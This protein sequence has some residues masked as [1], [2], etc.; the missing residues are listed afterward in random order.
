M[1]EQ[2]MTGP[3][4]AAAH[5]T[6]AFFVRMLTRDI[7]LLNCILDLIDNSIDAA[8]NQISQTPTTLETTNALDPYR[9]DIDVSANQFSIVDNCGGITLDIA[10]KYA[11]T[12]GRDPD[13]ESTEYT[14]GVYGIGMKRAAFKLGNAVSVLST[15]TEGDAFEVPIA[16]EEWIASTNPV[17]DFDLVPAAPL[18]E[19]GLRINITDLNQETI[20]EFENPTFLS[21]LRETIA[22]DYM[23]PLMNGIHIQVNDEE[24]TGDKI[25]FLRGSDFEPMRVHYHEGDVSVEIIAG[26][27]KRPPDNND[28]DEEVQEQGSGW[29]VICNGRVVLSADRSAATVWGNERFPKWHY[30]YN[31]FLGVVIFSS[32]YPQLLPMTTTKNG[33]DQSSEIYRR[34]VARMKEP[35]RAWIDY[36][37]KKKGIGADPEDKP[38]DLVV[39]PIEDVGARKAIK[40]PKTLRGPKEANILYVMS[41]DRVEALA[42]AFGDATMP[43]KEVGLNSFNYTYE[44]MVDEED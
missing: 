22:S 31:G 30:Q 20:D 15:P 26:M 19:S 10:A 17:W 23:L 36:T 8:W 44:R 37:N 40:L 34:A 1:P 9:I 3:T 5:P 4:K 21:E 33:V 2:T 32:R 39:V 29:Y 6:K 16:I 25:Q 14:I 18:P 27:V 7:S 35:T 28:P 11:F 12:F 43:Y 38:L 24:V 42:R 41:V 13:Y